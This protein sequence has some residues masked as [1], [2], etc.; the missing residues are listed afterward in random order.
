MN[1]GRHYLKYRELI[2]LYLFDTF[3]LEMINVYKLADYPLRTDYENI[4]QSLSNL[5][6][7]HFPHMPHLLYQSIWMMNGS[8]RGQIEKLCG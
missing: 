8:L 7:R 6:I 1:L 3:I 4:I 5:S 2:D